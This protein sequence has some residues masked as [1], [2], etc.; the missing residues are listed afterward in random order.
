MVWTGS[1]YS[2]LITTKI[3]H[4]ILGSI[5]NVDRTNTNKAY[6]KLLYLPPRA[7]KCRSG[8][9]GRSP[10]RI[11]SL[12]GVP[13]SIYPTPP[14]S[15]LKSEVH[16]YNIAVKSMCYNAF[17]SSLELGISSVGKIKFYDVKIHFIYLFNILYAGLYKII[18]K[19]W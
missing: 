15:S 14:H 6:W 4:K 11:C 10:C 8:G 18:F 16:I 3:K 19:K 2:W 1:K 9:S 13:L 17:F 12:P 5:R 7:P